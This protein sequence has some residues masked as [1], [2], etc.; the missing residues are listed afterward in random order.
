MEIIMGFYSLAS[1][2][3]LETPEFDSVDDALQSIDLKFPHI[4]KKMRLFWGDVAF[5]SY[6]DVLLID[7]RGGRQGFPERVM[8]AILYLQGIHNEAFPQYNP[9]EIQGKWAFDAI[10]F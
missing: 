8:K 2:R 3:I 1:Q 6:L 9:P 4:A 5:K 10:K 7:N